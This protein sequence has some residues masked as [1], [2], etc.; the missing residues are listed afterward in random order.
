MSEY[1]CPHKLT[2]HC[3]MLGCHQSIRL[4]CTVFVRQMFTRWANPRMLSVHLVASVVLHQQSHLRPTR[5]LNLYRPMSMKLTEVCSVRKMSQ[6]QHSFD[7]YVK[8][9]ADLASLKW[10]QGF[11]FCG[12]VWERYWQDEKWN[13]DSAPI[14][15]CEVQCCFPPHLLQPVSPKQIWSLPVAVQW[16][17]VSC[18]TAGGSWYW[19]T[20]LIPW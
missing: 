19:T 4:W 12:C 17:L 7:S 15:M 10:P 13:G 18:V 20:R 14:F 8:Q 1:T 2:L 16:I 3:S 5:I 9:S 6:P 11:R